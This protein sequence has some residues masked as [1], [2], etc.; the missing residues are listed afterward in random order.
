VSAAPRG[1]GRHVSIERSAPFVCPA[2]GHE[3][4]GRWVEDHKTAD[5]QCPACGHVHEATWPGFTFLPDIVIASPSGE[6]LAHYVAG[7]PEHRYWLDRLRRQ[8]ECP[9]GEE[10]GRGAA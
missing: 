5:Q 2:C 6:E 3:F 7:M 9:A 10:P 4:T 8:A 1:D